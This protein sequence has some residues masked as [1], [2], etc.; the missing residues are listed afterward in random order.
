[1]QFQHNAVSKIAELLGT[2]ISEY[3]TLKCKDILRK[4]Q[5]S[6]LQRR[7]K[8]VLEKWPVGCKK[9]RIWESLV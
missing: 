9:L 3:V 2:S 4:R 5:T 8:G 6:V 7:D 1:M